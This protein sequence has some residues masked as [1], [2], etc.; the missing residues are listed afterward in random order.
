M[1]KFTIKQINN[2]L[3]EVIEKQPDFVYSK[4]GERCY[5]HTGP[6]GGVGSKGNDCGGCVFGQAFQLLGI[7]KEELKDASQLT[8]NG[9]I[10]GVEFLFLPPVAQRPSYWK[11]MQ[12]EQDTG[13]AWGE[14]LQFLPT[15]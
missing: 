12:A 7:T 6:Q 10:N 15:T 2:A 3:Q 14:L 11:T 9:L 5:Y 1:K 13:S 4:G 8:S